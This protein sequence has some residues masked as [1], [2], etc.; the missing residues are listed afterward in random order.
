MVYI[1]WLISNGKYSE[2]KNVVWPVV[3]NDL[4][5]VAQ[6]WNETGYD[7]WEEV[8][9]SSV[10]TIQSMYRALVQGV[11]TAVMLGTTCPNCVSQAPQIGCYLENNFWNE[12]GGHI[13]ANIHTDNGRSQ[14]DAAYLLSVSFSFLT[15]SPPC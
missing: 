11:Q 15:C 1:N 9:G 3:M 10:F 13:I 14:V 12:T 6:Y 4:N 5:Y 2:A 7:L 8:A